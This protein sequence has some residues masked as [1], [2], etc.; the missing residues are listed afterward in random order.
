MAL[1]IP[2]LL[3]LMQPVKPVLTPSLSS[4]VDGGETS[5]ESPQAQQAEGQVRSLFDKFV[6][7]DQLERF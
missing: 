2:A 3:G 7:L 4:A 1:E 6:C 5:G